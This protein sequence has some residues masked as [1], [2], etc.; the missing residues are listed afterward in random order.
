MDIRNSLITRGTGRL[1]FNGI[2]L[3]NVSALLLDELYEAAGGE[4]LMVLHPIVSGISL[5]GRNDRN[6]HGWSDANGN[7]RR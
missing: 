5:L 4:H 1:V 7:K 3:A 2:N 6:C